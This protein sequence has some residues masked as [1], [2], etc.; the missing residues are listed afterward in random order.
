[1]G[2]DFGDFMWDRNLSGKYMAANAV[3]PLYS[4]LS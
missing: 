2:Q 1:M 3:I 4:L